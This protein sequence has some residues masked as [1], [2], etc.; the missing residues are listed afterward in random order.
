MPGIDQYSIAT[1][2]LEMRFNDTRLST[3]TGFVWERA[4]G[5]YLITNWHNVS[6]RDPNTDRHLSKTAAEPNILVGVFNT[7][8]GA[9]GNKHTVGIRIRDPGDSIN[10]LVHPTQK[11]KI[12]I[13]AIPLQGGAVET[14]DFHPINRMPSADIVLNVAMDVYVLGY[15]FGAG[16][17]G[18]PIWKRGSIASEP[19]LVPDVD[20]YF[21]IDTASRPGMSGSP[22]IIRPSGPFQDSKGNTVIVGSGTKFIGVYS[23]RLASQDSLE[24]QVGIVWPEK[25]IEEIIGAGIREYG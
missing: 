21:R 3:A 16:T 9:L 12:D 20:P 15:P 2:P 7:R 4:G 11:R 22:V 10:W 18:L 13:V 8:N 5:H 14:I 25:Y 17:T 24:A 6:G 1:V 19:Q 23:G